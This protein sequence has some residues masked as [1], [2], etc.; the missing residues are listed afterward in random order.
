MFGAQMEQGTSICKR[1][2]IFGGGFAG[3]NA[4][5]ALQDVDCAV[6]MIDRNNYYTF[7]PPL[8]QVAMGALSAADIAQPLSLM[9]RAPNIQVIMKEV[10]GFDLDRR[11]ARLRHRLIESFL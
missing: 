1:V 6:T 8:Y 3:L 9:L 11:N 2:L 7:Q 10:T 5:K 4:A